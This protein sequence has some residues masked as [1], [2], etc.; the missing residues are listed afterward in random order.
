MALHYHP[1]I[2]T[3]VICDFNSGFRPPEMVKRRPAIVMSPRLRARDR[4]CTIVPL[5]TTPPQRVM[6]YHYRLRL[7]EPLPRPYDNDTQ[8]VKADMV[9]TV[10][11]NRLFLPLIGTDETGRRNYD[12]R[13]VDDADIKKIRECMLHA[14]GMV[15]LTEYL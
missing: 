1:E 12:V 7:D 5:S 2:G 11:F 3:I 8:W 9:V 14:L 6:P 15:T 4:L 13:V 10:C